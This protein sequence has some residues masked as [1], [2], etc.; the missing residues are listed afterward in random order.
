MTNVTNKEPYLQAYYPPRPTK[1][2]LFM[3][4]CFPW[5]VIRFVILNWKMLKLMRDSH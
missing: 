2:T 1:W 3:R 5:Q 4:Q